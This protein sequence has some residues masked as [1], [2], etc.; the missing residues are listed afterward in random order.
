MDE[1][2]AIDQTTHYGEIHLVLH[3]IGQ[4][5]TDGAK[6][7]EVDGMDIQVKR[8]AEAQNALDLPK[9]DIWIVYDLTVIDDD[10]DRTT[11]AAQL[12]WYQVKSV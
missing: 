4:Y 3:K 9:T 12:A 2:T 5:V 1:K 10:C 7:Y 8:G 11:E 6:Y